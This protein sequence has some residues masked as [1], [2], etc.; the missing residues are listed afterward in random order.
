METQRAVNRLGT[1][2]GSLFNHLFGNSKPIE[3]K[4]GM[5]CTI[6]L[7]TDRHAC[8]IHKVSEDSKTIWISR[9]EAKPL[10]KGMTDS[11]AY[12]YSN[13]NQNEP[14]FWQVA[15]L[16]KDGRFHL[17]TT[18]KGSIVLIGHRREYYDFS[19]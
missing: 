6:L 19:F 9:D 4:P 3:P 5:G 16:R 8:T 18:M 2:T 12:E 7:W 17:G 11:Q 10:H 1:D 15:T 13:N 14:Q